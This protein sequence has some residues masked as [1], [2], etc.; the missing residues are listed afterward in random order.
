MKKILAEQF[1]ELAL[2]TPFNHSR[3]KR[4]A[5]ETRTAHPNLDQDAEFLL[6]RMETAPNAETI[7]D[8]ADEVKDEKEPE[9]APEAPPVPE[10]EPP[11]P[12]FLED[13]DEP[14]HKGHHKHKGK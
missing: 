3:V 10:P 6:Q 7:V 9:P 14:K 8:I 1:R 13:V 5:E 2:A 4:L 12:A 11:A